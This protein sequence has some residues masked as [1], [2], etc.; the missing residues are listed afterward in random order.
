[1]HSWS[2]SFILPEN[3]LNSHGFINYVKAADI[4]NATR[5]ASKCAKASNYVI[6]GINLMNKDI[7]TG[8]ILIVDNGRTTSLTRIK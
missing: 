1:M 3:G 7:P 2:I 4:A 8:S 6:T 5:I